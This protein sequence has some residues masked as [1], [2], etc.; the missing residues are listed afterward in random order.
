MPT[1]FNSLQVSMMYLLRLR[2]VCFDT[3]ITIS[4][5][6][7]IINKRPEFIAGSSSF[8]TVLLF[9]N[10]RIIPDFPFSRKNKMF[11]SNID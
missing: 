2:A 8:G 4:F 1:N 11:F 6:K 10:T 5:S 7:K 3:R 9:A